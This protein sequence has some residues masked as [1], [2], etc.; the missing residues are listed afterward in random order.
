MTSETS[1]SG[2]RDAEPAAAGP[3]IDADPVDVDATVVPV[4]TFAAGQSADGRYVAATAAPQG[5][6]AEGQADEDETAPE[7]ADT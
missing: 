2:A 3:R 4:G 7:V 5:S 1:R 6:F